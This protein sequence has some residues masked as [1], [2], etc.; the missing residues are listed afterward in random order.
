MD[1]IDSA[2]HEV[3]GCVGRAVAISSP[4]PVDTTMPRSPRDNTLPFIAQ[5][6]EVPTGDRIVSDGEV[7]SEVPEDSSQETPG[8]QPTEPFTVNSE[9]KSEL[10][11]RHGSY[12]PLIL[13]PFPNYTAV[14]DYPEPHIGSRGSVDT[15]RPSTDEQTLSDES[16]TTGIGAPQTAGYLGLGSSRRIQLGLHRVAARGDSRR[17]SLPLQYIIDE[18][19]GAGAARPASSSSNVLASW[20]LHTTTTKALP[21]GPGKE[22]EAGASDQAVMPRV[23]MLMAGVSKVFKG[24]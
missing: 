16:P 10:P 23:M 17:F 9:H 14:L 5:T 1:A 24:M 6:T 11:P 4:E 22:K 18:R 20:N 2:K 15:V 13:S 3:E 12:N 7:M 19:N 21:P 8:E